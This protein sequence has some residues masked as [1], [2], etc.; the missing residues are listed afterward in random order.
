MG[1]KTP[2]ETNPHKSL[3]FYGEIFNTPGTAKLVYNHLT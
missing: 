1:Y 3:F 2:C